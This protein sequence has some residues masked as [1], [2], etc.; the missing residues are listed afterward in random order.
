MDATLEMLLPY[1]RIGLKIT[2]KELPGL[3]A[4]RAPVN[5]IQ[6]ILAL[7]RGRT[8]RTHTNTHSHSIFF[9]YPKISLTSNCHVLSL[10][11][12]AVV[13]REV[14]YIDVRKDGLGG[15]AMLLAGYCILSYTCSYPHIKH[16]RWRKYH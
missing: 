8:P 13:L 3:I 9:D 6:G 12:I 7:H 16:D 2:L 14:L 5:P 11:R 4:N 15:V 10:S 1:Q